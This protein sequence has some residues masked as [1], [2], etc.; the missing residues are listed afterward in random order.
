MF[1]NF[2]QMSLLTMQIPGS[3]PAPES[4]TRTQGSA[5]HVETLAE[6]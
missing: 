6:G 5:F 1:P 3:T 4:G 2:G